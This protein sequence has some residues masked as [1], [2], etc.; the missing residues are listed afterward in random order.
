[1]HGFKDIVV[2]VVIVL[3]LSTVQWH[4]VLQMKYVNWVQYGRKSML[5]VIYLLGG[6]L[7]IFKWIGDLNPR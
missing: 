3:L 4:I 6:T 7:R 5:D 1:M 2:I